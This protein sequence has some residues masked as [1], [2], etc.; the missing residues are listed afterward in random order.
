MRALSDPA[1]PGPDGAN[2][3][4]GFI[5]PALVDGPETTGEALTRLIRVL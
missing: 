3:G 2:R 4:A 5:R 1:R